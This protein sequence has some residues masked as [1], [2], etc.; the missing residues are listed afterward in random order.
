MEYWTHAVPEP[1]KHET[2]EDAIAY[3]SNF[4][5]QLPPKMSKLY[6]DCHREDYKRYS[7]Q[8][9][10]SRDSNDIY[11]ELRHRNFK[12]E[13]ILDS[14]KVVL[15]REV[16]EDTKSEEIIQTL[17]RLSQFTDMLGIE[18]RER[19]KA[20]EKEDEYNI[21]DA[22][23]K[24]IVIEIKAN[25]MSDDKIFLVDIGILIDDLQVYPTRLDWTSVMEPLEILE[26]VIKSVESYYVKSLAGVFDP[27]HGEV[28]GYYLDLFFEKLLRE[29][30]EVTISAVDKEAMEQAETEKNEE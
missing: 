10:P 29:D 24:T 17:K 14:Y 18:M 22:E 6:L 11:A 7:L 1:M 30:K 27:Q 21:T 13:E 2:Q 4:I 12:N 26:E 8:M 5:T 16:N 20:M 28:N 9:I 25:G 19:M 3:L 15:S 23:N